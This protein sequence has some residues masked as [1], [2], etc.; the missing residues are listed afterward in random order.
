M[1]K[2]NTELTLPERK[3]R[4]RRRLLRTLVVIAGILVIIRIAMPFIAR[5]VINNMTGDM[6][7]YKLTI[8]DVG[9]KLFQKTI[10][11]RGLK[12]EKKNGKVKEPFFA[13]DHIQIHFVS[14]R[15][16]ATEIEVGNFKANLV[17]GKNKETSQLSL[18]PKW[19]E[20]AKEIPFHPNA[21]SIAS[22]EVHYYE[23]YAKPKVHLVMKEIK[24]EAKNLENLEDSKEKLPSEIDFSAVVEGAKFKANAKLNQQT[25]K[26]EIF[27]T[28]SLSPLQL[29]ELNGLL[30]AYTQF[31]VEKGTFSLYA[32]VHLK[33]N[34]IKG[35]GKPVVDNLVIYEKDK[36]K[37]KRFGK[38][39][40]EMLIQKGI[41]I[42]KKEDEKIIARVELS[43]TVKNPDLNI[44]QLII[45]ALSDSY[46]KSLKKGF[47]NPVSLQRKER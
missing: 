37:D 47:E 39:V 31:D 24:M 6:P 3:A 1:R 44:W 32:Q 28:T 23:P 42:F 45:S 10:V 36:D 29:A 7:D 25:E 14:I 20:L 41:N 43:G 19:I 12:L 34:N 27:V 16:K 8:N 13:C 21:V 30:R 9:I 4:R 17:K 33:N 38:R 35:Y 5:A 2:R 15:R 18:D 11:L 40:T 46:H 22:G 26:P